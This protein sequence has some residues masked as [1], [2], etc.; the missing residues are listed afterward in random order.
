MKKLGLLFG[1]ML[2]ASLSFGQT[3]KAKIVT[4]AQC[5][6]CKQTIEKAVNSLDGIETAELDVTSKK[7]RVKYDM[8]KISLDAIRQ[9]VAS[10]GYQADDVKANQKAYNNL[11]PCCQLG[12]HDND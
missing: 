4:T 12:G 8:S 3:K 5:G 10:V 7:L 9:K 11:P 6:M 2:V 1:L